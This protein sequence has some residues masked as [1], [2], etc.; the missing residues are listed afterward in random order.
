MR[1]RIGRVLVW[2]CL[3]VA[4][5]ALVCFG[6]P[7]KQFTQACEFFSTIKVN[8]INEYTADSGTTIEGMRAE[9][10][11]WS[12]PHITT[13]ADA[14]DS[15]RLKVYAKGGA[16]Y[17][18]DE[19]GNEKAIVDSTTVNAV[20]VT[21]DAVAGAEGDSVIDQG[22]NSLTWDFRQNPAGDQPFL[23]RESL[24]SSSGDTPL[25]GTE[26]KNLSNTSPF[27]AKMWE[28]FPALH[29]RGADGH[30]G[31]GNLVPEGALHVQELRD[32]DGTV[33]HVQGASTQTQPVL[34]L[35]RN[36]TEDI[37][38]VDD[39]SELT[40]FANGASQRMFT[41]EDTTPYNTTTAT[42]FK[43]MDMRRS[44]SSDS[45]LNGTVRLTGAYMDITNNSNY[46]ATA[47]RPEQS[48]IWHGILNL[49][50]DH[51][52]S[53]GSGTAYY[54]TAYGGK[55]DINRT[56]TLKGSTGTNYLYSYGVH[57]QITND[58]INS[59]SPKVTNIYNHAVRGDAIDNTLIPGA[60]TT[61]MYNYAISAR[62][63]SFSTHSKEWNIGLFFD[64]LSGGDKQYGIYTNPTIAD[65]MTHHL[66]NDNQKTY[67]GDDEDASIVY[68]D[69]TR[70]LDIDAQAQ[71]DSDLVRIKSVWSGVA[72]PT[73][74]G[75]GT[76]LIWTDSNLIA[77]KIAAADAD[78]SWCVIGTW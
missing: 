77:V 38:Q 29:I 60:A 40:L 59:D 4:F 78:A 10:S 42:N 15:G 52:V 53:P 43:M 30:V 72:Y 56:Q 54:S 45:I 46:E 3:I 63:S 76:Y 26:T 11:Y 71:S 51:D 65:T 64:Q 16:M 23:I 13:P 18:K 36:N 2:G 61:N 47:V 17:F 66:A 12:L 31:I 75:V 70:T 33:L 69:T 21:Q 49:N 7:T 35:E 8:V 34:L 48:Y 44:S 14:D 32:A 50:G 1:D 41:I 27:S 6:V 39:D 74:M 57:G 67:F 5:T 25:F 20:V 37:M 73:G 62:A 68:V 22:P 55:Y 58:I 19:D 24:K 28:A 9:N